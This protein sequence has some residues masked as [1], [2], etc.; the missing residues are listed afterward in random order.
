MVKK[1]S[2]PVAELKG[3]KNIAEF[4]GQPVSV[5]QRWA[6]SG[7]PVAHEGRSITASK[8]ELNRWL[9]RESSGEP[10]TIATEESDLFANLKRGL[11]Y[12]KKH[13]KKI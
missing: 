5:A 1:K 2:E 8:E 7:M 6:K 4:L 13:P 3:W 10:V 9:G 12:V 11:A